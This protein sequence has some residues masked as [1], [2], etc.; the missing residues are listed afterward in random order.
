MTNRSLSLLAGIGIGVGLMYLLD[1]QAGPQRRVQL[2]DRSLRLSRN[3]RDFVGRAKDDIRERAR[4]AVQ[5]VRS[6]FGHTDGNGGY[7]D[8]TQSRPTNE[9]RRAGWT[10]GLQ[11][12]AG[13]AG[14]A[15]LAIGAATAAKRI[16]DR[17]EEESYDGVGSMASE[18]MVT[19]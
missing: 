6:R 10:P 5:E 3:T 1:P 4:G 12:L 15:A 2:R 14:A 11:I 13:S 17:R 18:S 9:W 7:G 8:P 19:P 16:R